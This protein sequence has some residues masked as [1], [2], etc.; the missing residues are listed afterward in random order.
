MKKLRNMFLEIRS[1]QLPDIPHAFV[2]KL[3]SKE[4]WT[5][6]VKALMVRPGIHVLVCT[7]VYIYLLPLNTSTFSLA[8]LYVMSH[9]WN[10][11]T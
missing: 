3:V 1:T 7:Y 4:H 6:P 9:V 5:L 10:V 8:C 2:L 11:G